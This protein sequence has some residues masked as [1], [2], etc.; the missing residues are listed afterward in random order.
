V[1]PTSLTLLEQ[2][3]RPHAEA[4]WE[5][6]CRVYGAPIV[7]Y[8]MKLGLAESDA[9]D[10]LQETLIALVKL[11]PGFNYDPRRGRFRNY[12]LTIVHRQALGVF[13]RRNRSA[14]V[15]LEDGMPVP[16]LLDGPAGGARPAED[17]AA[18]RWQESLLDEAWCRLQRSG[19]IQPRT[20][21]IFEE[22]VLRGLPADEAAKKFGVAA[23]TVYQIRNRVIVMLKED[24][25]ALMA[26]MDPEDRGTAA[27][28]TL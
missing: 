27:F 8:G 25:Q 14:E 26:D 4:A 17:E 28:P 3:K 15:P 1:D 22:Y 9:R 24:V 5:R 10:V 20:L 23:N 12:V 11:L 7:R 19:Q 13:R 21:A 6:F 16:S 18:A 2:L